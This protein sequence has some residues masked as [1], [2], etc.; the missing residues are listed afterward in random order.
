MLCKLFIQFIILNNCL[1]VVVERKVVNNSVS[2]RMATSTYFCL[3][4]DANIWHMNSTRISVLL[5]GTYFQILR[6]KVRKIGKRKLALTS[7]YYCIPYCI[8]ISKSK[9]NLSFRS[10]S[11]LSVNDPRY[12]K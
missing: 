1:K 3:T 5:K 4:S 11:K 6:T 8:N 12:V 7:S 10:K 2:H 9:T